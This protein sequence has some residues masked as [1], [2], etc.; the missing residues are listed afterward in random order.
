MDLSIFIQTVTSG[1]LLGGLY[2]LIAL[3]MTLIFGVMRIINLAHGEFLM[4]GMYVS[5]ILF[6]KF[7]VDPYLSIVVSVPLLFVIG[8]AIQRF[9][10]MPLIKAKAPG[11]NQI[12]MTAGIGLVLT[13]AALLIFSPNYFTVLTTYSNA[14]ASIGKIS[15]SLPLLWDFLICFGITGILYLFIMKT[16]TGCSIR[17]VAQNIDSARLMGINTDRIM[18]ITFGVG[19]AL[20]GAAGTLFMPIFY[21]FPAIGELF[22]LKAFIV[23]VLGGMGSA[24]GALVG[25]VTLGVVE[26]MGASYISMALKDVL[27]FVIFVL[28]LIFRPSG[29]VGKSRF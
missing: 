29:L 5:Y 25:G 2:G 3:G 21:V 19:A 15:V 12:L 24:L 22:T 6:T 26:Q 8:I 17:A 13:N 4:I 1:V 18:I 7:G 28:V 9:L 23:T 20:V 16:D 11:E 14:T 10:L 27:G